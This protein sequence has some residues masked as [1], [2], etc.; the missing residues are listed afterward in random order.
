MKKICWSV[1]IVAFICVLQASAWAAERIITVSAAMSLK[2]AFEEIGKSHYAQTGVRVIFNFGASGDLMRQISAGAPVDVF[3]SASPK[4]MDDLDHQ[5]FVQPSSQVVF[6]KSSFV[7]ILPK[8]SKL[9]IR[10]FS[11]LDS[12]SVNQVAICNP[13]TSPA[14]RY[15]DEVL[16]YY[17]ITGR[18]RERL[19]LAENVRQVLDY[20][21]RGE[22]DAGIV[23]LTDA[24]IRA[25]EV[26]VAAIAPEA[27]HKPVVYPIALVKGSK[28][29]SDARGFISSVLSPDGRKILDK[30]GFNRGGGKH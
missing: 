23:Y 25:K 29:E 6:A 26:R 30:Y 18:I 28:N 14:G 13:K 1:L 24:L 9:L 21:A 19:I 15:A 4:D 8:N 7:L 2:N 17:N 3:A 11:D 16:K 20:V 10:T 12:G 5:G 22:V 27:S